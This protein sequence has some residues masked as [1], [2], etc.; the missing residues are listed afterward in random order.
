MS[1]QSRK[2]R[3]PPVRNRLPLI[4]AWTIGRATG[5]GIAAGL[6]ALALWPLY[7][8]YQEPLR[9]PYAAALALTGFCGLS[10][11]AITVWDLR[12]RPRSGRLRTIRA[13]DI[14][15]ALVM[16]LPGALLLPDLL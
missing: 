7:A 2:H 12:N 15:V 4:G 13:F 3:S 6:V 1:R 16:M 5:T 10:I 11:L 9:L 14:I 8:T